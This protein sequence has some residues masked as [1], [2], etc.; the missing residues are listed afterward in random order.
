MN[1]VRR[2]WET[3]AGWS[4][5]LDGCG[6]FDM[7]SGVVRWSS[8]PGLYLTSCPFWG[9]IAGSHAPRWA[10]SG[11]LV[12]QRVSRQILRGPQ[13]GQWRANSGPANEPAPPR[14]RCV[15]HWRATGGPAKAKSEGV[16]MRIYGA[17]PLAG[18]LW[19]SRG[20]AK[21]AKMKNTSQLGRQRATAGP[22]R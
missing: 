7:R 8:F 9:K 11:P 14:V 17:G 2:G 18:Q 12:A 21:K 4:N 5:H 3:A 20:P 16:C 6:H 15:G 19:A 13:V 1:S 10:S 22:I